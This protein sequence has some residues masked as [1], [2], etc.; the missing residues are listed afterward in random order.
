KPEAALRLEAVRSK[1]TEVAQRVCV[2]AENLLSPESVR[3]LCW[4]WEPVEDTV[5]AIDGFLREANA[6]QWQRELTVPVLTDAL[7]PPD[8]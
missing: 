5:A 4:D 3:R 1:L 8:P 2:P 6:R 7:S